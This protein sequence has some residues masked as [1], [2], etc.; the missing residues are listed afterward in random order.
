VTTLP[1]LAASP[2][3]TTCAYC[4]VGCGLLA[5][6]AASGFQLRGDPEHPSG[7][8]R[9]CTKGSALGDTL[10]ETDR[11]LI[12]RVHGRE[13]RWDEA[14]DA[15]ASGFRHAIQR[16]GP[17]S[18]A[19]Y[20]SGQL[21]T[22]DYYVANKLMKGFVG[23]ANIDTN[24]RLCMSSAVAAHQRAF[25]E[26]VV[27]GCYADLEFADLLVLVGSN[28]AW[29]HP[30]LWRRIEETKRQRPAMRIV[31][32]D[33][34]RTVTCDLADLHLPLKAGS[35]VALFAGLLV[36][37]RRRGR[38]DADFVAAHTRGAAAALAAAEKHAGSIGAVAEACGLE[39]DDVSR[40]YD[41][42]ADTERVVTAFS[43]GVN[44]SSSGTDKA[45]AILNC[46]LLTG[47]IG[48]PGTGPLSLTGQPNA[49][50]G[51][52]V[53]GMATMLAAH[54]ELG[55]A[56]HR[57]L[58]QD[59][60]Q[61]PRIASRPGLK[62]VELFEAVREGRIKALWILGTNPAVSLPDGDRV[63]RAIASCDFVVVSDCVADTDTTRLAHVL[64][65]AAAWGEKDG[66]MTNSERRISR[67]RAFRSPAG[68]AMPDWWALSQVASRLG[69]ASAFAYRSPHEIFVEHARLSALGNDGTR[70]FDLGALAALD[71][72]GYDRLDPIQWPVGVG[73]PGGTARLFADGRFFHADG[74]ARLV[75][76]VPRPP[77][78]APD[79]H[80]PFVLNTGRLRDQWHTMTRTGLSPR[81]AEHAPEPFVSVHPED[82]RRAGIGDGDL[83]RVV[84]RWGSTLLRP[85]VTADVA[86]GAL[87]APIHWS[88]MNSSD[89]R[90]GALVNP[91][92]DP[93]SGEPEFKH[94]PAALQR[95]AVRWHGLVATR[96]PLDRLDADWW[97]R[98]QGTGYR[99]FEFA[100]T[101][102]EEAPSLWAGNLL[103]GPRR[104]RLEYSDDGAGLYRAADVIDGVLVSC[105]FVSPR[106]VLP[107][108][109]WLAG[110][111]AKEVLDDGDREGLLAGRP[112]SGGAE[113]GPLVCSCF[114]V[115]RDTILAA[116]RDGGLRSVA[117]VGARTKAGSN[118]GTCVGEIRALLAAG[119]SPSI[120]AV[121]A[122]AP[123]SGSPPTPVS[124]SGRRTPPWP[125]TLP[126]EEV[127][128]SSRR[129]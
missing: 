10:G 37:L 22:E 27:P 101:E 123:A 89:G 124:P 55:N 86:R 33:P 36:H 60:W 111:F 102:R 103:P 4:G 87:F 1:P 16:H 128:R 120:S 61:S 62:A 110:L 34:R 20:V 98:V 118:C 114:G 126:G 19:L 72:P 113:T 79:E 17:D 127:A 68:M 64:L 96:R 95:V 25:G 121:S 116:I 49:M 35:D 52:E 23:S 31:V 76:T 28:A 43:Q 14:L 81:L 115:R 26:D 30:V 41:L 93:H 66:T 8:G 44:Q 69:H 65:P 80:H 47:R 11:L 94:T 3:R 100:M 84:T 2:T 105:V 32:V 57:R 85:Q 15:V 38:H 24:S 122:A 46:H 71:R 82:A 13:A 129:G 97:V 104:E 83:A 58:V 40:F 90:I 108:R 107:P 39:A 56:H 48:H 59:F 117:E 74:R 92:V 75:P 77:H 29:C 63:R 9:L 88:G 73:A 54:M 106:P 12:P 91:V 125:S 42:F 5:S 50:G 99:R 67:Q 7:Y 18:V 119:S 78:H 51:R 109:A 112:R 53:G 6:P 45:T 21:L 70:A